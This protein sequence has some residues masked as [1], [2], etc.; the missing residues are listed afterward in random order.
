MQ[1]HSI[2]AN[3]TNSRQTFTGV[4]LLAGAEETLKKTLKSE[5][6]IEVFS[7]IVSSRR[8][9]VFTDLYLF[10]NGKKLTARIINKL[11][12]TEGIIAHVKQ[13]FWQSTTSFLEKM[14]EK[15]VAAENLLEANARRQDQLNRVINNTDKI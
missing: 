5:K 8:H 15:T 14:N 10:G 12:S 11:D 13:K 7:E 1:V 2:Q 6:D 3:N 4:K 9:D